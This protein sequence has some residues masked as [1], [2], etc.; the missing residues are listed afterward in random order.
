M[1]EGN[2][3]G[4]PVADEED[5]YRAILYPWW[6]V[7]SENRPSSAAFD[8]DVFSV[9]RK[10]LTTPG[11]TAARFREISRLVEF[12][13]GKAREIGFDTRDEVDPRNPE[14]LAHARVYFMSK[15]GRKGRAKRLAVLCREVPLTG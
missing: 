13:C 7:E 6:W 11:K 8:Y 12:N 15:G 14:N 3:H 5:V 9:D 1:S 4:P 2:A 10:S